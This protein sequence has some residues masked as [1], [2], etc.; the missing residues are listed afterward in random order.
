MPQRR[1]L[2]TQHTSDGSPHCHASYH[3][4]GSFICDAVAFGFS[5]RIGK[6][7]TRANHYTQCGNYSDQCV[8]K[9]AHQR[10]SNIRRQARAGAQ[11][12]YSN[13][14]EEEERYHRG[15]FYP[16]SPIYNLHQYKASA[17]PLPISSPPHHLFSQSI[18]STV[19]SLFAVAFLLAVRVIGVE[20]QSLVY[21]GCPTSWSWVRRSPPFT[22]PI[23]DSENV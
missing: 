15:S 22:M 13:W 8:R 17:S 14:A 23:V 9:I 19:S 6:E 2:R 7:R 10:A 12:D 21:P 5:V 20:G 16:H 1:V 3:C 4:V 11:G 18:M